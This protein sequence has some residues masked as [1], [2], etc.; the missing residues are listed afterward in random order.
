MIVPDKIDV[1]YLKRFRKIILG[2]VKNDK[3]II[4]CGGGKTCRD[5]NKVAKRLAK[6][7]QTEL[8][9]IGIRATQINAELVKVIF[10]N[11]ANDTVALDP[12]KRINFRKVLVVAGYKP[13]WTSD[14]D[15][16]LF[17]KKYNVKD[18][19]NL[20]NVDYVYSKDPKLK[21]AKPLKDVSWD[22]FMKIVGTR[23]V[24]GGNYPFDPVALRMAKKLR[25]RLYVLNGKNLSS[26]NNCLHGKKFTGTVVH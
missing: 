12:N 16:V 3:V 13:G 19:I 14:Y 17:A 7:S 6:P 23:R 24:S 26:V 2:F 20:T 21:G 1:A 9:Y 5:Y 8:D 15:A 18:I 22:D 10:G 11:C 25:M 4:V